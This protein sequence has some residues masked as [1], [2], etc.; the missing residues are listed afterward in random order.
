MKGL[1]RV[2]WQISRFVGWEEG[3]QR[4]GRDAKRG[5]GGAKKPEL[6]KTQ[7]NSGEEKEQHVF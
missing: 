7:Q 6:S 1:E 2:L 4:A 3:L 5:R